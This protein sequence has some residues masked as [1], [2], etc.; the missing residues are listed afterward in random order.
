MY[1]C[2]RKY[3]LGRRRGCYDARGV[4]VVVRRGHTW[5][6]L[7]DVNIDEYPRSGPS[8]YLSGRPPPSARR[9]PR[10]AL[11]PPS[12]RRRR[13]ILLSGKQKEST[14]ER[15]KERKRARGGS[16]GNE[17]ERVTDGRTDD[18]GERERNDARKR[19]RISGDP[20]RVYMYTGRAASIRVVA[21]VDRG[22]AAAVVAKNVK[23]FNK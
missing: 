15:K 7:G 9:R 19:E 22:V 16:G 14:K 17:R 6:K 8:A 2:I 20:A 18:G 21:T 4:V 12:R 13:G 5:R 1:I 10:H 11:L 3:A 23:C